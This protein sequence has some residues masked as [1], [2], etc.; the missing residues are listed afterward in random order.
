MKD[1]IERS[2]GN[3]VLRKFIRKRKDRRLEFEVTIPETTPNSEPM[4]VIHVTIEG[5]NVNRGDNKEN[6]TDVQLLD[7]TPSF[8]IG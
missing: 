3:D 1:E 7:P 4:G 2:V 8:E 6:V 5:L